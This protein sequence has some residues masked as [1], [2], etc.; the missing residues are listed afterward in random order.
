MVTVSEIEPSGYDQHLDGLADILQA[1]VHDGASVGFILPFPLEE[2]RAFWQ[3]RVFPPARD[4]G[5]VLLGATTEDR[6]VGTVQLVTDMLPSQVHRCEVSKLLVHPDHRGQGIAKRLM[7]DLENR[8]R[9]MN[10]SLIT[11]DTKTGDSAEPLYQSLGYETAGM[12][13][14]Y[15]RNASQAMLDSTTWMYKNLQVTQP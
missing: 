13:P 12:T 2:S 11:L 15:C 14:N 8:A 3:Q 9:D 6:L 10:R 1:C 7:A 5:R 4:G